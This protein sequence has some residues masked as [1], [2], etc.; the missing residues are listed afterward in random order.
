M[1]KSAHKE[2]ENNLQPKA[3]STRTAKNTPNY[4]GNA[5]KTGQAGAELKNPA[6]PRTRHIQVAMHFASFPSLNVSVYTQSTCLCLTNRILDDSHGDE[7][8]SW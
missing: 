4:G 5:T 3:T 6:G 1:C 2:H 8:N 7:R